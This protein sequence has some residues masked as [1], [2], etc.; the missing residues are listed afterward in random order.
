MDIMNFGISSICDFGLNFRFDG[1][2]ILYV[3]VA[4][5]MW[6]MSMTYSAE[7]MAHYKNKLRYFI[8]SALTY[9]ATV[10]VFL[11][12]D[13]ITTFLFFE[14]MSFTSYVWV[15]QDERKESLRAGETYLAIAVMGGLVMLM[16]LFLLY[17]MTGTLTIPDID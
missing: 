16:G 5:F 1:F 15:V 4:T 14:I 12:A 8:F 13:L 17:S 11:S 3:C 2:R 9:I 6:I 10:G 7:Y